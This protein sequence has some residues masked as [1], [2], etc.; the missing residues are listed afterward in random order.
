MYMGLRSFLMSV[1]NIVVNLIFP[2][3]GIGKNILRIELHIHFLENQIVV[4]P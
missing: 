3:Q 4:L 1:K 2:F